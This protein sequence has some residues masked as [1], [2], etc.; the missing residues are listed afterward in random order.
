VQGVGAGGLIVLAQALVADIVSPRERGRYQGYFGAA[1]VAGPLLGGFLT[2]HLSWRWVFYVNLPL[3]VLALV[4]TSATLPRP[5]CPAGCASTGPARSCGRRDRVPRA[6]HHVGRRRVCLGS[7]VIVGLGI[8][9]V[10]LAVA[11][12][13]VEQ[14]A[15]EPAVPLRLFRLRTFN[16]AAG[17]SLIVGVALYG[18]ITYLQGRTAPKICTRLWWTESGHEQAR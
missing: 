9:T 1:S 15:E 11:F 3:G 14:R 5:T 8:V 17:V 2:D 12:V 13:A 18:A 10:A 7:G 4:V 6:A 16:I